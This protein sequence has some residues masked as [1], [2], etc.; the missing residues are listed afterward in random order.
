MKPLTL[1][2][3]AAAVVSL[4]TAIAVA[5]H[6]DLGVSPYAPETSLRPV[7]RGEQ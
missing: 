5:H 3:I 4:S 2:I 1:Y 6:L 7:A